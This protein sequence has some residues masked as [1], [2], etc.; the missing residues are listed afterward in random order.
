MGNSD[1]SPPLGGEV[2][3]VAADG[4]GRVWSAF[5]RELSR[6]LAERALRRPAGGHRR[7]PTIDA[8]SG[9]A[10][11]PWTRET[12]TEYFI[13][14]TQPGA[15]GARSTRTGLLYRQM[16]GRWC[17]DITKAEQDKPQRWQEANLDWVNRARR[18]TG[19]RGPNG[20]RT[21]HLFG[22]NFWGGQIIPI[23]CASAPP[24]PAPPPTP[25]PS[26]E[27]PPSGE[28]TAP[29]EDPDPTPDPTPEPT[30]EGRRLTPVSRLIQHSRA[31]RNVGDAQ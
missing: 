19:V 24:P 28:P 16:C 4:P 12:R 31:V 22:R 11:G 5:L 13:E 14:G 20:S 26:G 29:P 3:L 21:S 30:P 7:V 27:P 8:W 9:G 2:A 23:D 1:H 18:G 15:P 17:V 25:E 10:P 6:E